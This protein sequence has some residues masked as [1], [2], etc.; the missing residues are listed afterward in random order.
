MKAVLLTILILSCASL[1]WAGGPA[2]APAN[3]EAAWTNWPWK[4]ANF[5]PITVWLQSPK[6]AQ[7]FKDMGINLYVGIFSG[8]KYEDLEAYE[9]AGMPV[10][11]SQTEGALKYAKEKPGGVIVA[12]M[13][14]DEPDNAQAIAHWKSIEDL[15]AAW[16]EST[17]KTLAEW[18]TYGPPIPPKTIVA[19][20][21]KIKKND[22]TRPVM[23]NLGQGVAYDRYGGRG[24]RSGKTE[25]YPEYMRGCDI[26]S[27]DIY[28]VVHNKPEIKGNLWFVPL[29]VERLLKWG[30]GKKIVWNCIECTPISS[31][32]AIASPQQIKTEVWMSLIAGS[33]GIIYFVHE[34]KPKFIEAGV[35]SH[36]EQAKAIAEVNKQITSLA[37]VLNSP[38]IAGGVTVKSSDEKAPVAAVMKQLGG[39]TYVFAVAMRD[40]ECA[41]SFQFAKVVGGDTKAEVPDEG[42]TIPVKGGAFQ[43]KFKGY[44]VHL[45][46]VP[47]P[48]K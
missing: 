7:K 8:P 32:T 15:K 46:K 26:A 35:L 12:W 19:D 40:Q 28:P 24:Y 44:E 48:G 30:D 45:Y 43:D 37:P 17:K 25:D 36:P 16:P 42:R 11:C 9:K 27:F 10:I 34:F 20:Y 38:T 14:G 23:L 41:A 33:Q 21:E 2:K 22:P 39:A 1:A 31:D 18:G 4:D 3:P 29:G 13:H 5:F 6:N 47:A